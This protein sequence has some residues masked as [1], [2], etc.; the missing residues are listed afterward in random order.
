ML[1]CGLKT[2]YKLA[3]DQSHAEGQYNYG[4]YFDNGRG[5]VPD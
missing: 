4:F 2:L 5:V 1:R 3:A